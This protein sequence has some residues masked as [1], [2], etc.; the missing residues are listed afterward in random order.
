MK[1][2]GQVLVGMNRRKEADVNW[3][4]SYRDALKNLRRAKE[5]LADVGD[6]D[7]LP[8]GAVR[9]EYVNY[10][11]ARILTISGWQARY[12]AEDSVN[13][14]GFEESAEFFDR[15]AK[16]F[17]DTLHDYRVATKASARAAEM[18]S[19]SVVGN[20]NASRTKRYLLLKEANALYAACGDAMGFNVTSDRLREEFPLEEAGPVPPQVANTAVHYDPAPPKTRSIAS[21]ASV[22]TRLRS[23]RRVEWRSSIGRRRMARTSL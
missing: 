7:L 23:S 1:G 15:S 4:T 5:L 22:P 11:E 3:S 21:D 10:V 13:P 17:R 2:V 16:I 8:L 9:D 20:D 19:R 14:V 18:R 6:V 12:R